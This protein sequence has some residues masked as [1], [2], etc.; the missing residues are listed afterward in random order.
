MPFYQKILEVNE[1][2]LNF[3]VGK[4]TIKKFN[5]N[6]KKIEEETI[7]IDDGEDNKPDV[8]SITSKSAHW[9]WKRKTRSKKKVQRRP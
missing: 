4:T 3:F 1:G 6:K 7:V 8:M 5:R 9:P 2:Q